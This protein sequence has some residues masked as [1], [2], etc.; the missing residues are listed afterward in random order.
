MKKIANSKLEKLNKKEL[1][2]YIKKLD[3]NNNFGLVWESHE[4]DIVNNLQKKSPILTEVKKNKIQNDKLDCALNSKDFTRQKE[5]NYLKL[6]DII[7][8]KIKTL[9]LNVSVLEELVEAHYQE[10]KKIIYKIFKLEAN[11]AFARLQLHRLRT[12]VGGYIK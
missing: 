3:Q 12:W 2:E 7:I 9:Q 10:N 1:I 8:K 4:E 6:Q 11:N 5:K